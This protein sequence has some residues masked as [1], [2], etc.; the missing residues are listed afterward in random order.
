MLN[1]A[2]ISAAIGLALAAP[3]AS[4]THLHY[5]LRVDPADTTGVSVELQVRNAPASMVLAAQAHPEYDDKYWRYLSGLH[6]AG[7]NG[8]ALRV[9]PHDSVLWSIG[10]SEGDVTVQYRVRFPFQ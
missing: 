10:N 9:A 6:A 4:P 8:A 1:L 2:V 3:S 7:A 5:T